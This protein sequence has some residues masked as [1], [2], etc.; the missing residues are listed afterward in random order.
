MPRPGFSFCICPDSELLKQ[1]VTALL[2]EHPPASGGPWQR[3]AYWG[4]EGLGPKFW[5][6]LTLQS[7]MGSSRALVVRR[8]QN[9]LVDDW[10]KLHSALARPN[11]QAWPIFCLE[12]AFDRKGPKLPKT[13]TRQKYWQFAQK[14]QWVWQSAGLDTG[15]VRAYLQQWTASRGLRFA[16]GGLESLTRAMPQDAAG[17]ET[18]LAKVALALPRGGEIT[19]QTAE[20]VTFVP[21]LDIFRFIDALVRGDSPEVWKDIFQQQ[22]AGNEMLFYFLSLLQREARMLWQLMTGDGQVRLPPSVRT[23]KEKLA[24]DL[25]PAR[26]ARIWDL[27]LEAEMGVK[28]G[29][30]RPDQAM[31]MLTAGLARVF[32]GAGAAP[33]RGRPAGG[34]RP[35]PAPRG[36]R[37]GG[38]R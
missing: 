16:P 33:R 8:A 25:G 9:L 34:P 26:L 15:G 38:G 4:D 24:R 22:Q 18:E 31:E 19:P 12:V 11:A 17:L 35:A 32:A 37:G 23:R 5:E 27:A 10:D 21:E 20:L 30:R 28:T 2:A 36:G 3:L 6:H 7:L 29:E 1:H 14:K 13:L